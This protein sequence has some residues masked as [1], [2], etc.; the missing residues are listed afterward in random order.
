LIAQPLLPRY[1][2]ARMVADYVNRFYQPAA[3]QWQRYRDSA[4]AGARELAGWKGRVRAAWAHVS[5]RRLNDA[6]RRIAFGEKLRFEVA[7]NLN[8]L[9]PEDVVVELLLGRPAGG[10]QPKKARGHR[11]VFQDALSDGEARF[12][13]DLQPDVCGKMEYRI[14]AYPYHELLTHAFEMGMM[15]WL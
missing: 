6:R 10:S 13:L 11:F 3:R 12:V 9:R 5:L 15:A 4:F 8:G 1:N 2:S 14:R 7:V